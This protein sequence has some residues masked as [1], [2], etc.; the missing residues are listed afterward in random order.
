MGYSDGR[1]S[2]GCTRNEA[3]GLRRYVSRLTIVPKVTDSAPGNPG[4]RR[5]LSAGA[6]RSPSGYRRYRLQFVADTL[7]FNP[8]A[9]RGVADGSGFESK[10]SS[11]RRRAEE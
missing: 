11:G 9:H 6:S 5:P 4:D 2:E 1:Q 10:R 7:T 3:M 8:L